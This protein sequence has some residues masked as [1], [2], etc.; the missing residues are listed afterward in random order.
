MQKL[1]GEK[2]SILVL[3]ATSCREKEVKL[4]NSY[5]LFNIMHFYP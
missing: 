3:S 4:D 1:W 5:Q 2:I